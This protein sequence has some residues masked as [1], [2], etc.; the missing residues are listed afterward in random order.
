LAFGHRFLADELERQG[1]EGTARARWQHAW[2]DW[3][4]APPRDHEA[5][6]ADGD[7]VALWLAALQCARPGGGPTSGTTLARAA[8]AVDALPG[9]ETVASVRDH[10][11]V[12]VQIEAAARTS[13]PRHAPASSSTCLRPA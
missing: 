3:C 5:V 13:S 7:V 4:T 9:R 10:M 6:T 12:R 2:Q 11:A 8:L 1:I